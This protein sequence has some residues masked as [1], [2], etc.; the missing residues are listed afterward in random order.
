MRV[1]LS[2]EDFEWTRAQALLVPVDKT[3]VLEG[4][5]QENWISELNI[6]APGR[7]DLWLSNIEARALSSG[8]T[9]ALNGMFFPWAVEVT[10][11]DVDRGV[12]TVG[13]PP[14]G[15]FRITVMNAEHIPIPRYQLMAAADGATLEVPM[16]ENGAFVTYDNPTRCRMDIEPG[17]C[18]LMEHVKTEMP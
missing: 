18:I 14:G 1:R 11:A 13:A 10:Q 5:C 17:F 15:V 9:F 6:D 8:T 7:Y 16:D 4:H 12:T 3:R 2:S